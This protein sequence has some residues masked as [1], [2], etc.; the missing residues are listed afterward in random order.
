MFTGAINPEDENSRDILNR[1][2]QGKSAYDETLRII[3][4]SLGEIHSEIH[5]LEDEIKG[6]IQESRK[7][8]DFYNHLGS[9][10][11]DCCSLI[12]YG[13]HYDWPN[14]SSVIEIL[15]ILGKMKLS[16]RSDLKGSSKNWWD[17]RDII[18]RRNDS[19]RICRQLDEMFFSMRNPC[20]HTRIPK[21]TK[22][23]DRGHFDLVESFLKIVR[24]AVQA[25]FHQEE[26]E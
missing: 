22:E 14:S 1:I 12:Y 25:I 10:V 15:K 20:S 21:P 23:F 16:K 26:S 7:I 24:E 11:E 17:L 18:Q 3:D 9:V 19:R 2:S 4:E 8:N 6:G 13:T 5:F